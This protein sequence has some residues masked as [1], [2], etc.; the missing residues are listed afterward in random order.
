M[1]HIKL[2]IT[3]LL[4]FCLVGAT[5]FAS[6][7]KTINKV[8]GNMSKS[9]EEDV[10]AG[11]VKNVSAEPIEYNREDQR[12]MTLSKQEAARVVPLTMPSSPMS[13]TGISGTIHVGVGQIF[14][15]LTSL[16][17]ALNYG[18]TVSGDVTVLLDDATYTEPGLDRKS[19]V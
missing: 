2:L 10:R 12:Q 4:I 5:A 11:K 16:M 13:V 6:S 8:I 1:K 19:V 17:G 15:T 9:G 7:S 14:P 3:M 18:A